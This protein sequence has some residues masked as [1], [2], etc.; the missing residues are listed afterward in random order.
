MTSWDLDGRSAI[1]TGASRGIGRAIASELA[2]AGVNVVITSRHQG[3]ADE[4]ASDLGDRVVG[5]QAH[6]TDEAAAAACVQWTMERFGSVD[7]LVNNAG[8]NPAYGPVLAQDHSR[9]SKTVD[10]NLWAPILWT[11]LVWRAWMA[12]HGGA[13]VNVASIGGL[14]ASHDIG[15]YN[16]TKAALMQLTRQL[17]V[18]LAPGVRVNAVAP[19]VVRT[20][21][22]EALWKSAE[23]RI[24]EITLAGRLAEPDDISQVVAF[25]V[26]DSA[27]WITGQ[28][29]VADG[30]QLL[31]AAAGARERR[32]D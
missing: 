24:A 16:A 14:L 20:K 11:G 1:V 13:V 18:E 9:F 22:A 27:R 10:V 31:S 12:E 2:R 4:A 28:V 15:V 7:I 8:T 5:I 30:G 19:G 17:A 23:D 26:S 25:L 3:A 6:A 21:L 29:L 32:P